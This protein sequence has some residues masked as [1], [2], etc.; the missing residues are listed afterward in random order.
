[1]LTA[2]QTNPHQEK[3]DWIRLSRSQN[4][5]RSTFFHLLEIFGS[6]KSALENI[7]EFSLKGGRDKPIVIC[8]LAEAEKELELTTKIGAEILLYN[9]QNYPKLLKEIA[10][11]PPVLTARGNIELLGKNIL[12]I[13]GPRNASFNGCKFAKKIAAELGHRGFVVASGLAR[14]IDTAAH[15]GSIETG[16]IAVIAGGIDNIYPKENENLYYDIAKKG[17]IISEIPFGTPPRGGNFPQ[18][19]RIISGISLGAVIVEATLKSG[20]LITARFALEQ[21][22]EVFAVPGSPFDPRCQG[23]NRLIKQGAKL[24]ENIDDIIEELIIIADRSDNIKLME[25]ISAGFSGFSTKSPNDNEIEKARQ[26]ILSK[27]DYSAIS[28]D[29]IIT[30]LQIPAQIVN[31]VL[32]QLELADRIENKN[33]KICLKA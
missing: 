19:N 9:D 20:T 21:N 15:Q 22:R 13:V 7:G 3:I 26:L 6:A 31:I 4:I 11:P 27:I 24:I 1:M 12:A 18:R 23:T 29:E 2:N 25:P 8:S 14:G 30:E 5:G 17:V 33:G 10:D 28:A 32:V 16:T